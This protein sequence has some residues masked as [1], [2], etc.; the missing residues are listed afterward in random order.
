MFDVNGAVFPVPVVLGPVVDACPV[1]NG[2][3]W[4]TLDAALVL[5]AALG[6]AVVKDPVKGVKVMLGPLFN[7]S[8]FICGWARCWARFLSC[9][10]FPSCAGISWCWWQ[11]GWGLYFGFQP[12]RCGVS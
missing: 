4:R 2:V 6:Q 12:S 7:S 1:R 9:Q 3:E 11:V 10:C 5:C 8:L